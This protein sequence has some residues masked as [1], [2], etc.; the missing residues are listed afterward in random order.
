LGGNLILGGICLKIVIFTKK[1]RRKFLQSGHTDASSFFIP[2]PLTIALPQP[3]PKCRLGDQV[4]FDESVS[5]VIY[6]KKVL[7]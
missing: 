7:L 5:A 2:A 3:T 1:I 4:R 6:R